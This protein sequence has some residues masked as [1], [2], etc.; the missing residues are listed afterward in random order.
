MPLFSRTKNG[1][2]Q[3]LTVVGTFFAQ[4]FLIFLFNLVCELHDFEFITYCSNIFAGLDTTC[5]NV[6]SRHMILAIWLPL[7]HV[8]FSWTS[9]LEFSPLR[10]CV[11]CIRVQ[12][13]RLPVA[14]YLVT[15]RRV[16]A[17]EFIYTRRN[18]SSGK[19]FSR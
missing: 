16:F 15:V 1:T 2:K 5:V 9:T 12:T 18:E 8:G 4:I 14:S 10:F 7:I 11:S 3:G 13:T 19:R 6:P 17:A